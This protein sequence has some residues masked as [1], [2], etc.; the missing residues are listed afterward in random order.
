MA[1][2]TL[3]E[4]NTLN[5]LLAKSDN[6]DFNMIVNMF[7]K[8]Q[9]AYTSS[10]A[11]QFNVG[12]K[13]TWNSNKRGYGKQT[14]TITKVNKKTIKIVAIDGTQWSVSPSMLSKA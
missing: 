11:Q 7:N 5:K 13:V 3:N 4:V 10:V 8:A 2:L 14:G 9:A 6:E 12:E 1:N